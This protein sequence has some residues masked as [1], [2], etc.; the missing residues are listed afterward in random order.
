MRPNDRAA[1]GWGLNFL[2][3]LLPLV[4]AKQDLFSGQGCNVHGY[5]EKCVPTRTV[6]ESVEGRSRRMQDGKNENGAS[7]SEIKIGKRN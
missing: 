4:V 3:E 6:W 5:E 1:Y 2:A 7:V